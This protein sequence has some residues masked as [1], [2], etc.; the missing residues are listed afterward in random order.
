MQIH[1]SKKG[2]AFFPAWGSV[3]K[4]HYQFILFVLL[5]LAIGVWSILF[6][7]YGWKTAYEQ[8]EVSV[9]AA[10]IRTDDLKMMLADKQRRAEVKER[11]R[12]ASYPNPFL[13]PP[14]TL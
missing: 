6:L 9:R 14:K 7:E 8:P 3:L 12:S 4:R 1:L 2:S 13:A 5:I 11:V 10:K